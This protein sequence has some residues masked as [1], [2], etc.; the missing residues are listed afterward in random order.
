MGCACV[1]GT[2]IHARTSRKVVRIRSAQVHGAAHR[3]T[4]IL[5]PTRRLPPRPEGYFPLR[6]SI[7]STSPYRCFPCFVTFLRREILPQPPALLPVTQRPF[8]PLPCTFRRVAHIITSSR[9]AMPPLFHHTSSRRQT[10]IVTA[11]RTFASDPLAPV[12][13]VAPLPCTCRSASA[14]LRCATC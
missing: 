9:L 14:P 11:T 5:P 7:T 10:N 8:L 6:H 4:F 2:L 13:V 1:G 3:R 12:A